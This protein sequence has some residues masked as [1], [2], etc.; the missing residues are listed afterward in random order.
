[1][2]LYLPTDVRI[3]LSASSLYDTTTRSI[4]EKKGETAASQAEAAQARLKESAFLFE[5][6]VQFPGDTHNFGL[7]FLKN[8]PFKQVQVGA[9]LFRVDSETEGQERMT[10]VRS[11]RVQTKWEYDGE[12]D[13][14]EDAHSTPQRPTRAHP[15]PSPSLSGTM[16]MSPFTDHHEDEIVPKAL[17]LH[18]MLGDRSFLRG[19]DDGKPQRCMID[20]FFNGQLSSS[21]LVNW[22]EVHTWHQVFSGI[23]VGHMA[24]RPWVVV[25]P[26]QNVNGNLRG[27]K[28]AISV[29][30]RWQQISSALMQE[31][32]ARGVNEYGERPPSADYLHS[33][34]TMQMSGAVERFQNPD[35]R[36]FGVVD[37]V[38]TAGDGK[39]LNNGMSYLK[40]PMRIVDERYKRR[41]GE[42]DGDSRSMERLSDRDAEGVTDKE[43]EQESPSTPALASTTPWSTIPL[44]PHPVL[45]PTFPGFPQL[46]QMPSPLQSVLVFP[47]FPTDFTGS[48][49]ANTS[50]QSGPSTA[51][52]LKTRDIVG[53]NQSCNSSSSTPMFSDPISVL[54]T[55]Y[56]SLP[57]TRPRQVSFGHANIASFNPRAPSSDTTVKLGISGRAV[58]PIPNSPTQISSLAHGSRTPALFRGNPFKPPPLGPPPSVGFFSVPMAVVDHTMA[59]STKADPDLPPMSL[60]LTRFVITGKHGKRIVDHQW[61]VA[62]R[63]AMKKVRTRPKLSLSR[64]PTKSLTKIRQ[65]SPGLEDYSESV[66]GAWSR[67]RSSHRLTTPPPPS[68]P[69]MVD[70]DMT[71][72]IDKKKRDSIHDGQ[73]VR[74][75]SRPSLK[76]PTLASISKWHP[77]GANTSLKNDTDVFIDDGS[78][79]IPNTLAIISYRRGHQ[80]L[81]FLGAQGPKAAPF[82]LE[83]PEELLR[84]RARKQDTPP[85]AVTSHPSQLVSNIDAAVAATS[86]FRNPTS[87]SRTS[88]PLESRASSITSAP[89]SRLKNTAPESRIVNILESGSSDLSSAPSSPEVSLS[90]AVI[91]AHLASTFSADIPTRPLSSVKPLDMSHTS[92][93]SA[94][95]PLV[96]GGRRTPSSTSA[97]SSHEIPFFRHRRVVTAQSTSAFA[98]QPVPGLTAPHTSISVQ[99]HYQYTPSMSP[100]R[101]KFP[102]KKKRRTTSSSSRSQ[103]KIR[104]PAPPVDTSKNPP[105]NQDCALAFAVNGM[106]GMEREERV[107]RQVKSERQGVIDESEV[108]CG[109][110]FFVAG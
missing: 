52:I 97:P 35:G 50:M 22:K 107:L 90:D 48:S 98:S 75:P 1:M 79:T 84:Q 64:S 16:D 30:E 69:S 44:L 54:G 23:R 106:A 15:A 104:I 29:N 82:I 71:M 6:R 45:P 61:R 89:S 36:R 55:S 34:A 3:R 95:G 49:S 43:V 40:S 68:S 9:D 81:P 63:I 26:G 32:R 62:R 11:A 24:E 21:V 12:V 42:E 92:V 73:L 17:A 5:E 38:I 57:P 47:P 20:V 74:G 27:P 100:T 67:S 78:A 13:E 108:V 93:T 86:T 99:K 105:L 83:N 33:L 109:M 77:L 51:P 14:N 37:V 91:S 85:D 18:V 10:S 60:L 39:K 56:R 59:D 76:G 103:P 58:L 94:C 2:P 96:E 70:S 72:S 53:K 102:P 46:P 28:T 65:K 25:P 19:Y 101:P 87:G 41:Q 66:A 7:N 8:V 110:R 31:V 80:T 4:V 88:N